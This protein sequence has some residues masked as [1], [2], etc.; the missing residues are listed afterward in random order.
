MIKNMI[1]ATENPRPHFECKVISD[2]Y[3]VNN[4]TEAN[5]FFFERRT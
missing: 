2:S 1:E 3:I 4:E 5:R